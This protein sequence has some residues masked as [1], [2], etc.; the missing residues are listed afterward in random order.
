MPSPRPVHELLSDVTWALA[1]RLP[2][3]DLVP[4]LTRLVESAEPG[5]VEHCFARLELAALFLEQHPFRAARVAREVLQAAPNERAYLIL[6]IAHTALGHY[7]AARQA[8][9]RALKLAPDDP[10]VLHNFGH[11][12]DVAFE[13]PVDAVPYLEAACRAAPG[14]PALV[15]SLAHALTR[16]GQEARA[17]ALLE[18]ESHL[19]RALAR[20]TVDAWARRGERENLR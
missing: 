7:R 13:R 19:S 6:G 5:S 1:E 8:Y 15:S 18:R 9:E 20:A 11:L 10:S 12:L 17:V 3:R 16:T 14:E 4:M 2:K